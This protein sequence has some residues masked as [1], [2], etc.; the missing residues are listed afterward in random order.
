MSFRRWIGCS[1]VCAAFLPAQE[2][3]TAPERQDVIV[4][5]GAF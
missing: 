2:K 5:T 4:V 3:T 1:L